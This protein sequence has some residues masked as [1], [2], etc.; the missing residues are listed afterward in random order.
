MFLLTFRAK[1]GHEDLFAFDKVSYKGDFLKGFVYIW[2][3]FIVRGLLVYVEVML[4]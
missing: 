1:L 3:D 4:T 2:Q